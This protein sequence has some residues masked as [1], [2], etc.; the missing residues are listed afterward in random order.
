[1]SSIFEP[2]TWT[3]AEVEAAMTGLRII[4]IMGLVLGLG[5]ATLLDLLLVRYVRAG[6]ITRE[7]YKTVAFIS[8]IVTAGLVI[9]WI[10][11]LGFLAHYWASTPE[12]LG[13]PKIYAKMSIVLILTLN[14]IFIH[15]VV[16]P[17]MKRRIGGCLF[18]GMSK[19]RRTLFLTSGAVSVTSWY[20]PM[21]LG[22]IPQVN[23]VVPA[24]T[25]LLAYGIL[26]ALAVIMAH[27]LAQAAFPSRPTVTITRA[28][29][30]A[31]LSGLGRS[32]S[33][34]RAAAAG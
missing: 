34:M 8:H 4:H 30:E 11:G 6:E 27:I 14:G 17:Y 33:P 25:I 2:A 31:L 24:T 13:N 10:T 21:L 32:L 1:M 19:V 7:R 16:L 18:D 12:K 22:K 5:A 20:V 15:R 26:V 9:L 3:T 28:E 29:Y 23:F